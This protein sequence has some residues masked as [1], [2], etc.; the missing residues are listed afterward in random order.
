MSSGADMAQP[1]TVPPCFALRFSE[2]K[3]KMKVVTGQM[4]TEKRLNLPLGLDVVKLH[5]SYILEDEL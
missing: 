2:G 5:S 1:S 4:L 3:S